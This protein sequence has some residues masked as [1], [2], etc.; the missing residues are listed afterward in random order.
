[1]YNN[2]IIATCVSTRPINLWQTSCVY[3][4]GAIQPSDKSAQKRLHVRVKIRY[5]HNGRG[6]GPKCDE[7]SRV[8]GWR[9]ATAVPVTLTNIIY[10]PLSLSLSLATLARI[11]YHPNPASGLNDS[12]LCTSGNFSFSIR[13]LFCSFSVSP[14]RVHPKTPLV[15]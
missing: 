8:P 12:D 15:R 11:L 3:V 1:M 6:T 13:F 4:K 14:V 2:I 7:G 10:I 5:T 9:I